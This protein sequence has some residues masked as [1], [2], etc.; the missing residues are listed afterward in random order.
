MP[1]IGNYIHVKLYAQEETSFS[2]LIKVSIQKGF[3]HAQYEGK[4]MLAQGTR[5]KAQGKQNHSVSR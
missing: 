4:F 3:T 1:H 2:N 5:L